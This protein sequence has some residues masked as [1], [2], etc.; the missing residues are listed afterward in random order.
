M[1][2]VLVLLAA[3]LA[4]TTL[5]L[6][7]AVAGNGPKLRIL[8]ASPV[9]VNGRGFHAL[10]RLRLTIKT[11]SGRRVLRIRASTSGSFR[12]TVTRMGHFDPCL[13]PLRVVAIG[14]HGSRAK[15]TLP[16]RECPPSL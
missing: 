14:N 12:R 8:S 3:I 15:A 9:K 10:E 1:V 11:A 7:V 2:R 5:S 4:A 16:Q 6:A 13:G